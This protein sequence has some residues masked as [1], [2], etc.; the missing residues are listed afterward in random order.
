MDRE[1]KEDLEAKRRH[2]N[3]SWHSTWKDDLEKSDYKFIVNHL[4]FVINRFFYEI[5]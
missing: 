1:V 5:I 4:D 2:E 3:T